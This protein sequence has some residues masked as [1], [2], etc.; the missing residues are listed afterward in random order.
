MAEKYFSGKNVFWEVKIYNHAGFDQDL[1]PVDTGKLRRAPWT[2]AWFWV[3]TWLLLWV[4]G[5]EP[6]HSR[7]EA[8]RPPLRLDPT[9][10]L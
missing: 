3:D 10:T 8:R 6:E 1:P 9:S 2:C 5:V 4:A 7:G